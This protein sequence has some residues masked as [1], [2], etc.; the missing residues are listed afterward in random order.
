MPLGFYPPSQPVELNL[1]GDLVDTGPNIPFGIS[2]LGD[3]WTE[4][5]LIGFAYA[6][7]QRTRVRDQVQPYLVPQTELVDVLGKS[8]NASVNVARRSYGGVRRTPR[9]KL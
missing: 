2:F 9:A 4:A 7:E 3:K 6:F 1:R 8:G 5:A